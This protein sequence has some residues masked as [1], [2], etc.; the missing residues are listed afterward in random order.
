MPE[1]EIPAIFVQ[2]AVDILAETNSGL[3]GSNIVRATVAYARAFAKVLA[4]NGIQSTVET[5]LS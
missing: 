1:N 3:S 5:Y 2:Y 4:L